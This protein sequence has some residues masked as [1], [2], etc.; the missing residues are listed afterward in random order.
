MTLIHEILSLVIIIV[1]LILLW[2]TR[3]VHYSGT[4]LVNKIETDD[5][6]TKIVYQLD[7]DEDPENFQYRKKV[8]FKVERVDVD[9]SS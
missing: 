3:R 4:M 1:L 2:L 5:E 6:V 9:S 7:L 8:A